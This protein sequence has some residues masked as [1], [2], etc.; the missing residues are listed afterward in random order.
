MTK[1]IENEMISIK[2]IETLLQ[3]LSLNSNIDMNKLENDLKTSEIFDLSEIQKQLVNISSQNQTFKTKQSSLL[4]HFK[5]G[6]K[7]TREQSI[8]KRPVKRIKGFNQ[9]PIWKYTHHWKCPKNQQIIKYTPLEEIW[10][11]FDK[12]KKTNGHSK[13]QHSHGTIS[14]INT[15][16]TSIPKL[17]HNFPDTY[18]DLDEEENNEI[19]EYDENAELDGYPTDIEDDDD[20]HYLDYSDQEE[21]DS[22]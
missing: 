8:F 16:S 20:F 7:R 4:K 22:L 21:I 12:L 18:N 3:N 11:I 1:F 5:V 9:E 15:D 10:K 6:K 14:K 17:E 19:K 13:E 2:N